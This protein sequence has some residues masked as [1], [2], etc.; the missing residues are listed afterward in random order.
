[1][2]LGLRLIVPEVMASICSI[3]WF[4]YEA[5]VSERAIR[6][7]TSSVKTSR[8][9]SSPPNTSEGRPRRT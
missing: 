9:R 5:P 4:P 1:M 2:V 6:W 8:R 7:K 3:S